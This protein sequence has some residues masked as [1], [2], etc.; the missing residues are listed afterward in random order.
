MA[1]RFNSSS[2]GN[3]TDTKIDMWIDLAPKFLMV[4]ECRHD[5][6]KPGI[7]K[8]LLQPSRG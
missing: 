1:S 5:R 3:S 7:V 6:S 8:Q 4:C 2:L